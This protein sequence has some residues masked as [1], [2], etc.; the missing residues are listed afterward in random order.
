MQFEKSQLSLLV[1]DAMELIHLN[2]GVWRFDPSDLLGP[3]GGFGAVF[4]GVDKEGS[5]VAVKRLKLSVANAAHRELSIA[6]EL[7]GQTHQHVMPILDSG[8]DSDS[9]RY[10][11][12]MPCASKSLDDLIKERGSIGEKGAAAILLQITEGLLEVSHLVHRDLKPG[13]ILFHG[14]RWKIAD[15]G[16]ARFVEESTSQRTL[17]GC[18]SPEYAAP[19]Q[20]RLEHA[21]GATDIYALGCIGYTLLKGSPPFNGPAKED[22]HNQHINEQ[23]P[24]MDTVQPQLRSLLTMMLRKSQHSRPSLQR[25]RTILTA[26]CDQSNAHSAQS[27]F[28]DLAGAGAKIAERESQEEARRKKEISERQNRNALCAEAL[29]IL[30]SIRNELFDQIMIAAPSAQQKIKGKI[31]LGGASLEVEEMG[32]NP[33]DKGMF[34]RSGWDVAAGAVIRVKQHHPSYM[35]SS[36][37]WYCKLHDNDEYRWREISYFKNPFS[38]RRL[39][40]EPYSIDEPRAADDAVAPGVMADDQV[41][42]GPE[43]IDDENA[44][45]FFRRWADRFAAAARCQ[46]RQPSR[47]PLR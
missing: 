31:V 34:P 29:T 44:E 6:N 8:Q 37:L 19:E 15:F 43:T 2:M 1:E 45:S 41:A 16:I 32:L 28:E 22:F 4:R 42:W 14:D 5:S 20:W 33:I 40:F 24:T 7:A 25:V 10:Y 23:P 36:S 27:G 17:K 3:E 47:L 39:Q 26:L 13:N 35:W 18:L 9:E 12:V 38:K 21:S 46:L 11:V 30:A